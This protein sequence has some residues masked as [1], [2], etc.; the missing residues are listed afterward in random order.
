MR[1]TLTIKDQTYGAGIEIPEVC[2]PRDS[3]RRD[4][5]VDRGEPEEPGRCE[6]AGF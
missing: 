5:S 3:R 6:G 1:W 2:M 4:R